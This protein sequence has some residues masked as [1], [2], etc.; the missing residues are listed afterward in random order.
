MEP[1]SERALQKSLHVTNH[2]T[3]GAENVG[4]HQLHSREPSPSAHR[5]LARTSCTVATLSAHRT[6]A[7]KKRTALVRVRVAA[8]ASCCEVWPTSAK[9]AATN[10]IRTES[11]AGPAVLA[12][13]AAPVTLARPRYAAASATAS[14]IVR[15][16]AHISQTSADSTQTLTRL[17]SQGCAHKAAND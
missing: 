8:S 12:A 3:I 2:H 10:L 6:F 5:T 4:A 15:A 11:V 16:A 13:L 7:V 1:C 17:R 9:F 14:A